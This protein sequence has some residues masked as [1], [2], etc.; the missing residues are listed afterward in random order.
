MEEGT[1]KDPAQH[2]EKPPLGKAG[3]VKKAHGRLLTSYKERYIVLEKT[4]IGVYENEDLQN[5]LER[6]D[7]ENYEKCHELKSPFKK[8][9]RLILIRSSK[10]GNKVHDVKLQAQSVEEK[11]AWIKTL[12]EGIDRA[13]NK[14][15]DEVKVES[16]N[17]EHVTRTRPKGNRNRRP[18]TRIH[19]KEVAIVSSDGLLRLD[20]DLEDAVMPNETHQSCAGWTTTL[21][22][23]EE[24]GELEA[25][26]QKTATEPSILPTKADEATS[27]EDENPDKKVQSLPNEATA[28]GKAVDD[29]IPAV[30]N[31]P[32]A[33]P[34]KPSDSLRNL[35]V[36]LQSPRISVLPSPSL[37]KEKLSLQTGEPGHEVD[38]ASTA[39]QDQEKD[40]E[41]ETDEEDQLASV[42]EE[43]KDSLC[44]IQDSTES[45]SKSIS[46]LLPC[47]QNHEKSVQQK[48]PQSTPPNKTPTSSASDPPKRPPQ[49]PKPLQRKLPSD[50]LPSAEPPSNG[51]SQSPRLWKKKTGEEKSVESTRRR[52]KDFSESKDTLS[53]SPSLKARSASFENMLSDSFIC[54]QLI[55]SNADEC[56]ATPG[57]EFTD[58]QAKVAFEMENTR[59]LLSKAKEG[60]CEEGSAEELLAQA[61]EK[62][63]KADHVLRELN[64]QKVQNRTSNRLSW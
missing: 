16:N 49:A 26:V 18:P 35:V 4:E 39:E 55:H 60:S 24:K 7:L 45:L 38:D 50:V 28:D 25:C 15:F 1:K 54:S 14:A 61:M 57:D 56:A 59:K 6:F 31:N 40:P 32:P 30:K 22:E 34:N 33:P 43:E 3:W 53:A 42:K 52:S 58:L 10:S 17:L 64:K 21:R 47:K 44:E 20:L 11:E 9:H 41:T 13:K 46:P 29:Q 2:K 19:M 48:K 8:K 62:L 5:C 27:A 51:L 37:T 63:R 12:S 23:E 36:T